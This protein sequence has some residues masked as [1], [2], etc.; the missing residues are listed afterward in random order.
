MCVWWGG[1]VVVK[2]RTMAESTP[3]TAKYVP[4]GLTLIRIRRGLNQSIKSKLLQ[5]FNLAR[6]A[7]TLVAA[8]FPWNNSG[9]RVC[10]CVHSV[11][12]SVRLSDAAAST[13]LL[14]LLAVPPAGSHFHTL[15][16]RA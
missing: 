5:G 4:Q 13:A 6:I 16:Y 15:H 8:D 9:L 7:I 2:S 1:G 12:P 11:R 14:E 3:T 10:V